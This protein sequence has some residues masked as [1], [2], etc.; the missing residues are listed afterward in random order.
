MRVS[1]P[2]IAMLALL[3][4]LAGC[5][6]AP[7]STHSGSAKGATRQYSY[8]Y[9]SVSAATAGPV[10]TA[11]RCPLGASAVSDRCA[12]AVVRLIKG[13]WQWG[14]L[15]APDLTPVAVSFIGNSGWIA[16][17][18]PVPCGRGSPACAATEVL[19]SGNGGVS[20]TGVFTAKGLTASALQ[21]VD[22]THGFMF[23]TTPTSPQNY[24]K[25][26]PALYETADGGI[27]WSRVN[28][29]GYSPS[30]ISFPTPELGWLSGEKCPTQGDCQGAL[31]RSRNGG[32]TWT[33]ADQIPPFSLPNSFFVDFTSAADGW[34]MKPVPAGGCNTNSC[35]G[36]LL[37]TANGG[38]SWVTLQ[39]AGF[40]PDQATIAADTGVGFP[41]GIDMAT[42]E[43]GWV[44]V[45]M[46]AGPSVGGVEYTQD[47]GRAFRRVGVQQGWNPLAFTVDG[48]TETGWAIVELKPLNSAQ[49][50]HG[51]RGMDLVSIS[52]TGGI[53]EVAL[54]K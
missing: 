20:W 38:A 12:A 7:V 31:L 44:P 48:A 35:F 17:T 6:A 36:A 16:A 52:P 18:T 40:W 46:G 32:A 3:L 45:Q 23:A 10:V 11:L 37:G 54:P 39:P 50:G 14:R 26:L 29:Q 53:G 43:V 41:L 51:I 19:A 5:G 9:T 33:V 27:S 24:G 47:G 4:V 25:P 13:R 42:S 21:F 34:L 8:V 49:A 30:S 2:R 15:S 1:P 22:P 28:T